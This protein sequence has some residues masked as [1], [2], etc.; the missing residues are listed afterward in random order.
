MKTPTNSPRLLLLS[1]ALA[2]A[3]SFVLANSSHAKPASGRPPSPPPTPRAPAAA[4]SAAPSPSSTTAE[5]L[6]PP[7]GSAYDVPIHVGEVCIFTFPEPV[8]SAFSSSP[9]LDVNPWGKDGTAIAVRTNGTSPV[10]TLAL[11]SASGQT[12]VNL[13]LRVVPAAAP[14]LTLVRFKTATL[15]E[16]FNAKV[17]AEV[18]KQVAPVLAEAAKAK[19]ALPDLVRDSAEAAIAE[20]LLRRNVATDL[21]AH[22]RIDDHVILHVVRAATLGDDGYLS[23]VVENHSASA[24]RLGSVAVLVGGKNTAGL[25]RLLSTGPAD[26]DPLVLGVVAPG[27]TA[28]GVVVVRDVAQVLRKQLAIELAEPKGLRKLGVSVGAA[29]K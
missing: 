25:V 14:A 19:A 28:R 27:T 16:V 29:F 11:S 1:L 2:V 20:R 15:E 26:K 7:G 5:F 6:V 22:E 17:A 12:K 24:Y 3:L 23:F 9:N 13:T 8:S 10:A 4:T 18:A 21:S